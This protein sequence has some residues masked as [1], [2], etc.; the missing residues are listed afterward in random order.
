MR[1][2]SFIFSQYPSPVYDDFA[3][4]LIVTYILHLSIYNLHI[5]CLDERGNKIFL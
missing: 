5:I 4:T 2:S 1:R 3:V